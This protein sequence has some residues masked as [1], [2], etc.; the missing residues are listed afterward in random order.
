[1][2]PILGL[3]E[4]IGDDVPPRTNCSPV[5]SEEVIAHYLEQEMREALGETRGCLGWPNH[6]MK[7]VR[8]H[9]KGLHTSLEA[10]RKMRRTTLRRNARW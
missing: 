1:M 7:K 4:G 3:L 2:L 6:R 10:A 9:L 8:G 5:V